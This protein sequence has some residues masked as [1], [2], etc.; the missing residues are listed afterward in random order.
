MIKSS[1]LLHLPY[2]HALT[3]GGIAYA[4]N[5][6]ATTRRSSEMFIFNYLKHIIG[7]TATELAFRHHLSEQSIPFRVVTTNSFNSLDRYNVSLGGHRCELI[8]YLINHHRQVDHLRQKPL[9]LL[10]A[11]ALIPLEKFDTEG[12]KK[13]DIH[14]FAFILGDEVKK[15]EEV[16]KTAGNLHPSYYIY[17]LSNDWAHPNSWHAIDNLVFKSECETPLNV[18]LG[19]LNSRREFVFVTMELPSKKRMPVEHEFYSLAYIHTSRKPEAR[20][21]LH[22]PVHG[23]V[24]IIQI[25]QW[26]NIWFNGT[27]IVLAGWLSHE[28]YLRRAKV[29]N[30]GMSTFQFAHTRK[31]NLMVPISELNPLSPLLVRV[32]RWETERLLIPHEK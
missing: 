30:A 4:C 20:I 8:C 27:D 17:P 2:T 25:H 28:E 10:Q 7:V 16:N 11:P 19:G 12:Y 14:I 5:L 6:L 1:D 31:K 3:Q 29:L 26:K 22:S 13:D 15:Q 9:T 21:G 23:E 32:K 18:E 24:T